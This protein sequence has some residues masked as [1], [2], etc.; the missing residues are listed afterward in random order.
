MP[1]LTQIQAAIVVSPL[2]SRKAPDAWLGSNRRRRDGL[3]VCSLFLVVAW[4]GAA[5]L[6]TAADT[7]IEVK[8]P[9]FTVVSNAGEG[10]ARRAAREFEQV[11]AAYKK[12][13]PSAHLSQG[14]PI[15]V[16]ALKNRKTLRRWAPA[17]YEVKGG[18][19]VSSGTAYGADRIY[20]LLRTDYRPD[21]RE[22]TLAFN[23]Y[24]AYVQLLLNASFERRL[25]PWLSNGLGEVL[26]NT[27]VRDKE[28]LVGR[29]IP[30]EFRALQQGRPAA[31]A[32]DPRRPA[33]LTSSQ[34]GGS[35]S[36]LRRAE[37]RARSLPHVRR[38]GGPLRRAASIPAALAGR[39]A[40]TTR[41]SRKRSA[42]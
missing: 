20:L 4:S 6:A 41:R 5:G 36:A 32:D 7:W 26:G 12:L 24:R 2:H 34:Q 17:Y 25:P 28:I 1:P 22:V 23:L 37:L 33:R 14:R 21:D 15:I 8:S 16:L 30:W 19:D 39:T 9:N 11:R 3:R 35:A 40:P 42:T 18:I 29:P 31:P 13:W 27:S 10:K 38:S